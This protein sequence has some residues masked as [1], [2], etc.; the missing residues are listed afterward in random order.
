MLITNDTQARAAAKARLLND[1]KPGSVAVL[2]SDD[3]I[4]SQ[5]ETPTGVQRLSFTRR[6]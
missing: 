2:R 3:P 6:G 4:V 1:M 5:F